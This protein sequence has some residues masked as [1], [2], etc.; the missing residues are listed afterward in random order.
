M[1]STSAALE[2][3][4]IVNVGTVFAI[5]TESWGEKFDLAAYSE[6]TGGL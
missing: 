5:M 4:A 6:H 2:A 1:A 3:G